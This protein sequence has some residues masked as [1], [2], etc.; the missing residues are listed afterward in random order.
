MLGLVAPVDENTPRTRLDEAADHLQQRRLARSRWS[1][2]G[3]E[4]AGRNG[5]VGRLQ[6]RH[7][8][9]ALRQAFN[10]QLRRG[11][12][13][14]G[15]RRH[16]SVFL[17]SSRS[18]CGR[19]LKGPHIRSAEKV[20]MIIR[21]RMVNAQRAMGSTAQAISLSQ[22]LKR[23]R[24]IDARSYLPNCAAALARSRGSKRRRTPSGQR[25]SC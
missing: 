12:A 23:V 13:I 5:Q 20:R 3:K 14:L 9:I 6:G 11:R 24:S 7:S 8:A 18:E 22:R 16:R 25:A 4:L 10:D 19:M 1:E 15:Y 21:L 2:Q 17:P